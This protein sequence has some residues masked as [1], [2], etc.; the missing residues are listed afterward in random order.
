[1]S[2]LR[3]LHKGK[4][5]DKDYS[6]LHF[7]V[8]CNTNSDW[9]DPEWAGVPVI[10]SDN[11]AKDALNEKATVAFTQQTGQESHWY[12]VTNKRGGKPLTDTDLKK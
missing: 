2:L 4:C 5:N 12:Y 10:V 9:S 6:L 11:T 3:Q 1:V 7:R 8:I